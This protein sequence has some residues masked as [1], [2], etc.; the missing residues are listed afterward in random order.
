MNSPDLPSF[1]HPPVREVA[2]GIRFD[3][4]PIQLPTVVKLWEELRDQLSGFEQQP[5]LPPT[6]LEDLTAD[7]RPQIQLSMAP[8]IPQ[9]YWFLSE[10]GNDVCQVQADRLIVNWRRVNDDD[11]YPRYDHVSKLLRT[12]LTS[13]QGVLDHAGAGPIRPLQ[14]EVDYVNQIDRGNG[15]DD[16]KDIPQVFAFLS[17]TE[18]GELPA[19]SSVRTQLQFLIPDNDSPLG[20]LYLDAVSTTREDVP[21][22]NL[23]LRSRVPLSDGGLDEALDAIDFGRSAIVRTFAAVTTPAMHALW[24]RK[25]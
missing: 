3:P 13:L 14:A 15:W 20:R 23:V 16:L 19:P 4:L 17:A 25:Q 18:L 24:G 21:V 1:E 10:S 11:V 22:L 8:S 5:A 7:L 6:P 9:R 2:L 12:C